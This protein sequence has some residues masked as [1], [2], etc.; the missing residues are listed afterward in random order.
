MR[1]SV[2]IWL[3]IGVLLIVIGLSLFTGVMAACEWDWSKL[4]TTKYIDTTHEIKEPFRHISMIAAEADIVVTGSEDGKCQV[5]CHEAENMPHTV[6]VEE[7]SLMIDVVDTRT[8][9]EY[10]GIDF[11]TPKITVYLPETEYGALFIVGGTGT[12]R[13]DSGFTFEQM[14]IQTTTGMITNAASV[15]QDMRLRTSTGG[16]TVNNVSANTMELWVSTGKVHASGV[17]CA[18]DLVVHVSTGRA[19][20]YDVTCGNLTSDGNTGDLHCRNVIVS[21]KLTVE[22]STGDVTL[23]RCDAAELFITTDTGDVTGSLLSEKVFF[24]VTDTG[25]VTVPKT[26]TGGMCEIRTNTGDIHMEIA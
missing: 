4:S 22:R 17:T 14:D 24:A 9:Y 1:K 25:R 15:V 18:G 16:I 13:I 6:R 7:G 11:S 10:L 23:N 12:L 8:W 3:L 2:K 5:V 21:D 19:A 20:I 26:I